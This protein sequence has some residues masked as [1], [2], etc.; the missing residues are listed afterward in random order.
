MKIKSIA[1]FLML[2]TPLVVAAVTENTGASK[3]VLEGGR[4]G[5]VSFPHQEH[6]NTLG[7]CN[8]CHNLF[9]KVSGSIERLKDEGGLK[10]KETMDQCMDCHK[11]KADKREKSGPTSCRGCHNK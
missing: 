3:I 9:P 11:N 8:L 5:N 6:Q 2:S 1:V 7:D 10:K 4:R